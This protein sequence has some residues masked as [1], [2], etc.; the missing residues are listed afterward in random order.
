MDE[1]GEWWGELDQEDDAPN[2][3]D[4]DHSRS[5]SISLH[6]SGWGWQQQEV[7]GVA[8]T[9]SVLFGDKAPWPSPGF[10]AGGGGGGWRSQGGPGR[11]AAGDEMRFRTAYVHGESVRDGASR[12]TSNQRREATARAMRAAFEHHFPARPLVRGVNV[13]AGPPTDGQGPY[14]L[15]VQYTSRPS[16]VWLPSPR[17]ACA[18]D[19]RRNSIYL[20]WGDYYPPATSVAAAGPAAD[21]QQPEDSTAEYV[22]LLQH[23]REMALFWTLQD[24]GGQRAQ[25][26]RNRHDAWAGGTVGPDAFL[27]SSR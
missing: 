11:A 15:A 10:G 3:P 14:E 20:D 5:Y 16:V 21:P 6:P 9:A 18:N 8:R 25:R 26:E 1:E 7:Q 12:P 23:L 17:S 19:R 13:G 22:L 2:N 27:W 4:R 24:L